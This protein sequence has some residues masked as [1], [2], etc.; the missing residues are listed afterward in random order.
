MSYIKNLHKWRYIRTNI[1]KKP[2]T[3]VIVY[4]PGAV[5]ALASSR[6]KD[7]LPC[8]GRFDEVIALMCMLRNTNGALP[9]VGSWKS[10]GSRGAI[11]LLERM[12]AQSVT[13]ES[14]T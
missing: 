13:D 12:P 10:R 1:N 7:V 9:G 6:N 8:D 4:P 14:V 2:V 11:L 5:P 3:E